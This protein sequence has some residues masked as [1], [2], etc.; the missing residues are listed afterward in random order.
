MPL[1]AAH[2]SAGPHGVSSGERDAAIDVGASH[3]GVGEDAHG[4][5]HGGHNGQ[6]VPGEDVCSSV[7]SC[8][9]AVEAS[10]SEL[11]VAEAAPRYLVMGGRSTRPDSIATSP[12][13]PPPR[14]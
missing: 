5:A 10:V 13:L 4:T 11:E 8:S 3:H 6:Q 1:A 14:A 7:A 12:E 9:P 2:E